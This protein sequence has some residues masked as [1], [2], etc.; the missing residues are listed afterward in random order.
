MKKIY[1][2]DDCRKNERS[3]VFTSSVLFRYYV[4]SILKWLQDKF[5]I[6]TDVVEIRKNNYRYMYYD[7]N[8]NNC[9]TLTQLVNM[10]LNLNTTI[11]QYIILSCELSGPNINVDITQLLNFYT[12]DYEISHVHMNHFLI[13]NN[14]CDNY[15]YVKL[16]ISKKCKIIPI[17][18]DFSKIKYLMDLY[19]L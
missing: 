13:F 2:K 4:I 3:N 7:N 12:D 15:E 14:L 18:L 8:N 11:R 9:V 19:T 1:G 10:K 16:K 5:D 6:E 17:C